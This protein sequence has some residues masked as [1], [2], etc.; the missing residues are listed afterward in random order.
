VD[1]GEDLEAAALRELREETGVTSVTVLGRTADWITYDFPEGWTGSKAQK[2][3]RG[4]KQVWFAM[5]F[6]GED[7]EVNL[8]THLPPEFDAWRWGR[9]EDAPHRVVPFKR[10]TYEHLVQAFAPHAATEVQSPRRG[11]LSKLFGG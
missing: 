5:R 7:A 8:K 4:Q 1:E 9:L 10:Q 3:W 6:L 11:W 2:G